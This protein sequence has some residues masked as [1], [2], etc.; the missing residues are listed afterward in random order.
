MSVCTFGTSALA[1]VAAVILNGAH[2]PTSKEIHRVCEKLALISKANVACFV[3]KYATNHP[4][5]ADTQPSAAAEIEKALTSRYGRFDADVREALSTANLLH[6]N[7]DDD[8][9][10]FLHKVD[11]AADALVEVLE[12][13]LCAVTQNLTRS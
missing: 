11:G 7:C 12:G 1:N 5:V 8:N 4:D 13:L 9:G 3:D 10:N 2:R 6:Y